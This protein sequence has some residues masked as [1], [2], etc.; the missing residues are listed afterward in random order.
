MGYDTWMADMP[1]SF[2]NLPLNRVVLPGT[3]DSGTSGLGAFDMTYGPGME[4]TIIYASDNITNS[5]I[6][7]GLLEYLATG[8][9]VLLSPLGLAAVVIGFIAKI[10]IPREMLAWSMAQ[11]RDITT[12]LNDGIR[13]FDLR[14]AAYQNSF[15]IVHGMYSVSVQSVLQQVAA[16]VEQNPKELII[17]DFNH[18][19][20][21]TEALHEQLVEMIYGTLG[22]RLALRSTLTPT[23]TVQSFWDAG[24]PIVILYGG[25]QP[26]DPICATS[27]GADQVVQQNDFLWPQSSIVSNWPNVQSTSDLFSFLDDDIKS[28][29][30]SAFYVLQGILTPDLEMILLGLL[31]RGPGNLIELGKETSPIVMDWVYTQWAALGPNIIIVDA[32]ESCPL[33][34]TAIVLNGGWGSSVCLGYV[35]TNSRLYLATSLG[36]TSFSNVQ[37]SSLYN[38]TSAGWMMMATGGIGLA[39][40]ND[41]LYYAWTGSNSKLNVFSSSDG[42]NF[43][44]KELIVDPVKN[45]V[46]TALGCPALAVFENSLY[47]AWTGT[48]TGSL[49]VMSSPDGVNFMNHVIIQDPVQGTVPT[50]YLGPTLTSFNDRLYLAW[51]DKS[52]KAINITSSSDGLT[53]GTPQQLTD[54]GQGNAVQSSPT[55]PTL[56]VFNDTLYIAW[57]GTSKGSVNLMS[58]TDGSTFGNHQQMMNAGKPESAWGLAGPALGVFND[59][60]YLAWV[61]AL[62]GEQTHV[63]AVSSQ[64]G[65]TFGNRTVEPHCLTYEKPV[66]CGFVGRPVAIDGFS[67][68][69]GKAG[70]SV[71]IT[72]SG[73]TG[74]IKVT[75]NHVPAVTFQ[76][77][78]ANEIVAT[79]PSGATTGPITI[80]TP[81]GGTTMSPEPFII[82]TYISGFSPEG[83]PVGTTVTIAGGGLTGTTQVT[84]NG[85][86]A[87][88]IKVVSNTEL[89][90]VVPA[91]AT[92]GVITVAAPGG[93]VASEVNFTVGT[94]PSIG[95]FTPASGVP[96]TQVTIS[97]A[98]LTNAVAVAFG[99]A[100]AEFIVQSDQQIT[101]VVPGNAVPGRITVT[102]SDGGTASSSTNFAVTTG[103]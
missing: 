49:N 57:I 55:S 88:T 52:T 15:F 75:F 22:P 6:V 89:T 9:W 20:C 64:D 29:P 35:G 91:A 19:Y 5:A 34:P 28:R 97:G 103:A 65:S 51:S 68:M 18:F 40:F 82:G 26:D 30:S 83:G 46:Q 10:G 33:V 62:S 48:G 27:S 44:D 86:V 98:N 87:T 21:M 102:T 47:V 56:A 94:P 23:S 32:Y 92:T 100:V 45:A 50:A 77:K 63:V 71:T 58:S 43:A 74:A 12:Q 59:T 4:P 7:G 37:S 66:L 93:T 36:S 85:K 76:V 38:E 31:Y 11:D 69:A 16:F 41:V 81:S 61:S 80:T 8:P 25:D 84:F 73:F 13:Y 2:A 54:P 14:V 60:L 17:L 42:V 39:V 101:V 99:G 72:G 95:G 24:T 90:A 1:P 79:V 70:T 53:F 96:G 78:S 67:P 3:H